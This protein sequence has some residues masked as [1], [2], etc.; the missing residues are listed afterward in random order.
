MDLN[1]TDVVNALASKF[2]RVIHT[3]SISQ[4][5]GLEDSL[6]GKSN[7]GHT[8]DSVD[9]VDLE[10]VVESLVKSML[11]EYFDGKCA[12]VEV[13]NGKVVVETFED[14]DFV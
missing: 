5:E 2:A 12:T 6:D 9:V 10:S 1:F 14:G 11:N 7:T 13:V 3:H 8:H 4:V